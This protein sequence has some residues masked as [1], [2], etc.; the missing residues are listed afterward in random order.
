MGRGIREFETNK[1][2]TIMGMY[3]ELILGAKLKKDTPDTV[4]QS[5]QYLLGYRSDMPN[6]FPFDG[7]R[8]PLRGGSYY[9]GVTDAVYQM[10]Y[11]DISEAWQISTRANIKNYNNEIEN[12]LDWLKPHIGQGSGARE[13]YAIVTYE[14]SDEPTIYYLDI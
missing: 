4:I 7:V 1:K 8:N 3:T 6:G 2:L 14:E 12:F 13:F 5:L 9:F 11:D 10:K